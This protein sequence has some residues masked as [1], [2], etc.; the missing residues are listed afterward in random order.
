MGSSSIGLRVDL[1]G[2]PLATT[3]GFFGGATG[4]TL[5]GF[6]GT[7]GALALLAGAVTLLA[8]WLLKVSQVFD[9]MPVSTVQVADRGWKQVEVQLVVKDLEV[10]MLASVQVAQ[11]ACS[12]IDVV[13]DQLDFQLYFRLAEAEY[14]LV[15]VKHCA[16]VEV[17]EVEGEKPCLYIEFLESA[18][19]SW[20]SFRRTRHW[21]EN[22]SAK[23][24]LAY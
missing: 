4:A 24:V 8:G 14:S 3:A 20:Y 11:V 17:H 9:P 2:G 16:K 19:L 18:K 12:P 6:A 13:P 10:R 21:L 15:G 23:A 1:L 7:A 22:E 5:W